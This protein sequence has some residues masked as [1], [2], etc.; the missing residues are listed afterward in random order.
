M[1]GKSIKKLI[2]EGK[3]AEALQQLST[4]LNHTSE[5]N[6]VIALQSDYNRLLKEKDIISSDEY[7]R[8]LRRID[9]AILDLLDSHVTDPIQSTDHQHRFQIFRC[10]RIPQTQ[11]FE[12][13]YLLNCDTEP[14]QFFVVH[15]NRSQSPRSFCQ[16]LHTFE[17]PKRLKEINPMQ[18]IDFFPNEDQNYQKRWIIAELNRLFYPENP[19]KIDIENGHISD[20]TGSPNFQPYKGVVIG[21]R[22]EE[23]YWLSCAV[24][25]LDW[26][27]H[28]YC[29]LDRYTSKTKVLFI[30]QIV[31]NEPVQTTS[32]WPFGRRRTGVDLSSS[33]FSLKK[34]NILPRLGPVTA[35]DVFRWLDDILAVNH[36]D[37]ISLYQKHFGQAKELPMAE[38]EKQLEQIIQEW[39]HF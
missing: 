4:R 32:F 1:A 5:A 24:D 33:L 18:I 19:P 35:N 20:F 12:K 7:N 29:H 2:E 39:N 11:A 8:Y 14:L 6:S 38:V 16:R 36:A 17:I 26:F 3:T 34:L 22:I 28:Q 31:Y 9:K 37:Q 10:D 23:E 27:I 21:I 30:F 15:G 25:F 13:S